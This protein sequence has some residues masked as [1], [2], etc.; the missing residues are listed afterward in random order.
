M[1]VH[2][3]PPAAAINAAVDVN[4]PAALY[5]TETIVDFQNDSPCILYALLVHVGPISL[6]ISDTLFLNIFTTLN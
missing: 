5:E 6:I 1:S 2:D 3:T 4:Y